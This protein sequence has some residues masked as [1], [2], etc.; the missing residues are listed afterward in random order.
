MR[1]TLVTGGARSGKSRFAESLL[2][3]HPKVGYIATSKAIDA[4]MVDRIKKHREQ[5]PSTWPTIEQ[6]RDF[7]NLPDN[8]AFQDCEIFLLDCVT[9][10]VTNIMFDDEGIDFD[11]CSREVIEDME[12]RIFD[13]MKKLIATMQEHDKD[14][15]LVTNEVGSGLVPAYRLGSIY[16]DIAG[17]VNQYLAEKADDVYC[18]ISGLPLKLK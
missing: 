4:D 13:E 6:Y 17:R 15:I 8:K 16:R 3:D 12:R 18:I 1:M 14:L 2:K 9:I 11:T 5:R 7:N 10:M